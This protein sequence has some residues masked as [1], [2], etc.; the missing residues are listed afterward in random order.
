M[1]WDLGFASR[2]AMM[3]HRPTYLFRICAYAAV[4]LVAI[5]AVHKYGRAA[6]LPVATASV[7]AAFG[8]ES[9]DS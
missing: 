6:L 7:G 2:D 5:W 9:V 8:G 3:M 1:K 4:G